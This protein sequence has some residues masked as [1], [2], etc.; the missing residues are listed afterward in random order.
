MSINFFDKAYIK[1]G[2]RLHLGLISKLTDDI[3]MFK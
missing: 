1:Q 2:E 3:L